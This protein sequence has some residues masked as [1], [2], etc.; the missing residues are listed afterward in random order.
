MSD[1]G[2][3][4]STV[5]IVVVVALLLTTS[6]IGGLVV[7]GGQDWLLPGRTP[8][9][10]APIADKNFGLA[11]YVDRTLLLDGDGRLSIDG[12]EYDDAGLRAY[13]Q[14]LC[15]GGGV[16]LSLQV[17]SDGPSQ[18]RVAVEKICAE[19]TGLAPEVA[20]AADVASPAPQD[21]QPVSTVEA[22]IESDLV[23]P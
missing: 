20:F 3:S 16:H 17:D 4:W 10:T 13:L 2:A 12:V 9:A 5:V 22:G 21:E 8:A 6:V 19:I 23:A 7:F 14:R 1:E 11:E 18:R 15:E